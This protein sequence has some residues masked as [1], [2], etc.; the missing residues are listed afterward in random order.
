MINV[1][2][3]FLVGRLCEL[4]ESQEA[5][6]I[7]EACGSFTSYEAALMETGLTCASGEAGVLTWT[8]DE[9]TPDVVYYQVR[10]SILHLPMYNDKEF[11]F[12]F[13]G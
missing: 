7:R 13:L 8:P 2:Y 11:Y 10:I 9:N 3:A 4:S 5:R 1:D 12:F 6:T